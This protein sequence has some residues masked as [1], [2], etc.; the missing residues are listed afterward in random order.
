MPSPSHRLISI[1]FVASILIGHASAQGGATGAVS[2]TV[3][4]QSGAVVAGADVHITNQATG[5]L[6]R[7]VKTGPDGSFSVPLLPVGTYTVTVQSPGF[8][9]SDFPNIVVRVT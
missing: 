4:D 7:A 5:V 6:E 9:Q 1:V 8:A 2:G 3:Q